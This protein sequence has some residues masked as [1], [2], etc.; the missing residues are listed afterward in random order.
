MQ[1][2]IFRQPGSC[3][4]VPLVI[5]CPS[6]T[7]FTAELKK[8]MHE[9][10]PAVNR[11]LNAR[12]AALAP[13]QMTWE[14]ATPLPT[15]QWLRAVQWSRDTCNHGLPWVVFLCAAKGK[16]KGDDTPGVDV[17]PGDTESGCGAVAHECMRLLAELKPHPPL[18]DKHGRRRAPLREQSASVFV[19][20]R[21]PPRG[22]GLPA[23][24][25]GGALRSERLCASHDYGDSD[26]PTLLPATMASHLLLSLDAVYPIGSDQGSPAEVAAVAAEHFPPRV[27]TAHEVYGLSVDPSVA[28]ALPWETAESRLEWEH[29]DRLLEG[30]ASRPQEERELTV[31]CDRY[32][33]EAGEAFPLVVYGQDGVGKASLIARVASELRRAHPPTRPDC[34]AVIPVFAG[35]VAADLADCLR[36]LRKCVR[37]AIGLPPDDAMDSE[38]L[39]AQL[40][41]WA[42][43]LE[44]PSPR[45]IVI[46][47]AALDWLDGPVHALVPSSTPRHVRLVVSAGTDSALLR[48]FRQCRP[49]PYELLVPQLGRRECLKLLR[50]RVGDDFPWLTTGEEGVNE[51]VISEPSNAADAACFKD[52]A[53]VPLYTSLAVEFLRGAPATDEG[54]ALAIVKALPEDV[55]TAFVA[56]LQ[57]WGDLLGAECVRH[58]VSLLSLFPYSLRGITP[59]ELLG[60]LSPSCGQVKWDRPQEAEGLTALLLRMRAVLSTRPDGA[61][62]L[63]HPSLATAARR[64]YGLADGGAGAEQYHCA[65]AV[66][67]FSALADGAASSAFARRRALAALPTCLIAAGRVLDGQALLCDVT[68]AE[69]KLQAG[70]ILQYLRDAEMV[71]NALGR[72]VDAG[73][74]GLERFQRRPIQQSLALRRIRERLMEGAKALQHHPSIVQLGINAPSC[75]GL[76]K[77]AHAFLSSDSCGSYPV[78]S[79]RNGRTRGSF[80]D[81]SFRLPDEQLRHV[82]F[83][84]SDASLLVVTAPEKV[85]VVRVRPDRKQ[86]ELVRSITITDEIP[87]DG[88]LA[89][90]FSSDSQQI[91]TVCAEQ[92]IVFDWEA[93]APVRHTIRDAAA[94][95]CR[96]LNY[97]T[98]TI[99]AVHIPSGKGCIIDRRRGKVISTLTA[100]RHLREG[101]EPIRDVFFAAK[102]QAVVSVGAGGVCVYRGKSQV[103]YSEHQ[104]LITSC[105]ISPD[106][107]VGVSC[108]GSV[109]HIWDAV[110][111]TAMH[112]ITA[113][114]GAMISDVTFHPSGHQIVTCD[115]AGKVRVWMV[116]SGEEVKSDGIDSEV[117]GVAWASLTPNGGRLVA[118]CGRVVRVWETALFESQGVLWGH[119]DDVTHVALANEESL[120][121]SVGVDGLVLL[122]DVDRDDFPAPATWRDPRLILAPAPEGIAADADASTEGCVDIDIRGD[123]K[124]IAGCFVGGS[125]RIWG[126]DGGLETCVDGQGYVSARFVSRSS[127]LLTARVSTLAMY[128]TA[129]QSV[130]STTPACRGLV[131]DEDAQGLRPFAVSPTAT[132]VACAIDCDDAGVTCRLLIFSTA[133]RSKKGELRGH[134]DRITGA[135]FLGDGAVVSVS[136]D[137]TMRLWTLDIYS[138]RACVQLSAPGRCCSAQGGYAAAGLADGTVVVVEASADFKGLALL[139]ATAHHQAEVTAVRIAGRCHDL[140]VS[141]SA[142]YTCLV[143]DRAA[144]GVLARVATVNVPTCVAVW[145]PPPVNP[146]AAVPVQKPLRVV[147]GDYSGHVYQYDLLPSTLGTNHPPPERP[148]KLDGRRA[149]AI[150]AAAAAGDQRRT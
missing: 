41:D 103:C 6:S 112:C 95:L 135:A 104:G 20:N 21:V 101:P 69:R 2:P 28:E 73:V 50:S 65:L 121:A 47:V 142:D 129:T 115:E 86:L 30:Y 70:L 34:T 17:T 68:F 26:I 24:V 44:T 148:K 106:G 89:S 126:Q 53:G 10:L 122:W 123:G 144:G 116:L 45:K 16:L 67:H 139:R 146:K 80:A 23:G 25:I 60:A 74:L 105:V 48:D 147:V 55:A 78:L 137:S 13:V 132:L 92:V 75:S 96:C 150:A 130:V 113:H 119:E 37:G 56:L 33:P 109:V 111:G 98:N 9:V 149:S 3:R 81:A 108:E 22:D 99:C 62:C 40:R 76:H 84:P 141:T 29:A 133:E 59:S 14:G 134:V 71:Q 36:H 51:G 100:H 54:S 90:H 38:P 8:L 27:L 107:E 11:A 57:I 124:C 91:V 19:F 85:H 88:F 93:E 138:E 102:A 114:I 61:M 32:M 118:R 83:A 117:G 64:Y 31:F 12:G 42:A 66:W 1:V 18:V 87:A 49:Q 5:A 136:A 131:A 145:L 63:R 43:L 15:S 39:A 143:S 77:A 128:D 94:S 72:C 82:N 52:H 58:G 35:S 127:T 97:D 46:L 7:D 140:V 120:A 110:G 125:L 4:V 79:L